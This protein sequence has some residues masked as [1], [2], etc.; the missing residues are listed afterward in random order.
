MYRNLS[1][2]EVARMI[3]ENNF[4][5]KVLLQA[6]EVFKQSP[7]AALNE[8]SARDWMDGMYASSWDLRDDLI[9]ENRK[10]SELL[11][12]RQMDSQEVA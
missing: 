12:A 4:K 7:P 3:E 5:V 11:Q 1:N 8:G 10:L 2:D 6:L 9:H